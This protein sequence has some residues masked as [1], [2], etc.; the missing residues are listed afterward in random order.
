MAIREMIHL[1]PVM[2]LAAGIL[3]VL[4]LIALH[5]N[6]VITF[7]LTTGFLISAF[8]AAFSTLPQPSLI[9]DDL[10]RID[11]FGYFY[12]MIILLTTLAIAVFSYLN[13]NRF[14]PEKRKEEF[15]ALLM[16]AALGAIMM[17]FSIHFI[18][19]FVSLEVLSVSLYGLIAYHRTRAEA[20]E[21]GLKYLILAALSTAFMLMGMAMVYAISGSM[22]FSS[23]GSPDLTTPS[24]MMTG[25]ITLIITG[26]GFK[27]AAV[28][29]HIWTPDV[30]EGASSPVTAF[31]ASVS[32]GS[33]VAVLIRLFIMSDLYHIGS[34]I[35]IFTLISIFSM[36]IGNLLALL[37][38]NVKRI[39]AYSSI[40][41]FGYL[42]VAVIAGGEA[43]APA[44]TF[45]LLTYMI[46]IVSA[47][48]L[49]TLISQSE[50][51]ATDMEDYRGLFWKKPLLAAAFTLSLLSLAGIPLTAGFIGKFLVLLAGAGT[52][53]WLLTLVLV[54]SSVIGLYY[55][56]RLIVVMIR[57]HDHIEKEISPFF[58]GK[59]WIGG[60]LVLFILVLLILWLGIYPRGIWDLITGLRF[61]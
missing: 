9:V 18:S 2:I 41:H 53:Q 28:P 40:A 43:G 8:V 38:N 49:V 44:A 17:A 3:I 51:E 29:F 6:H 4:I 20:I 19:F 48:G 31:I 21:A 23:I 47:F 52:A 36:V 34:I 33:I 7:F 24:L 30:Y 37:Q 16:T 54:L 32:K 22:T 42:L 10:F 14:Y 60:G 25:G 58:T 1:M 26:I 11:A 39:L 12:M 5:R 45:Y 50:E 46:T 59:I 61:T 55:Y 56:L 27:L 13:L 35:W 15:Y 57:T